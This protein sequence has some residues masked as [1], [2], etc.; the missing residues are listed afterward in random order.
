MYGKEKEAVGYH[1]A[2]QTHINKE[3]KIVFM[4]NGIFLQRLI[5]ST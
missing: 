4:T 5:H 2:M 3:T 1:I